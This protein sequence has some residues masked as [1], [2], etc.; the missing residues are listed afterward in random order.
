MELNIPGLNL[1][2]TEIINRD[3]NVLLSKYTA[4]EMS[5]ERNVQW[6]KLSGTEMSQA[7]MIWD[8]D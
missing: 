3:R 1:P 2:E 6:P 7:E 5:L 8:G 4:S